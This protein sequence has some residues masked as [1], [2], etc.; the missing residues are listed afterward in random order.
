MEGPWNGAKGDNKYQYNGKE[1]NDD[2]GLGWNDYGARFYDAAVGRWM[3]IDPMSEKMPHYSLYNYAFNNPIR[4][5]DPD[6]M[7]PTPPGRVIA[8]FFH[9]GPKG[10]GKT[11]TDHSYSKVGATGT[12]FNDTYKAVDA[13]GMTMHG[14]IIA[15]G[16]TSSSGVENGLNFLKNADI[17]VDD[18]VLIYGYS[19]GGDFAVELAQAAKEAGIPVDL[20]ITVDASDGPLGQTTVDNII[21]DNVRENQNYYQTDHLGNFFIV[22]GANRATGSKS[23]S[24]SGKSN[25][26]GSHGGKNYA[27]NHKLTNVQNHN[28]TGKK[29]NGVKVDHGN[30][31]EAARQE[32]GFDVMV[33]LHRDAVHD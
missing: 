8:V 24:D 11:Q 6:G 12:I 9:G 30:I 5:V 27:K 23:E 7:E 31:Q 19:Y 10:E 1:W 13:A 20:L 22:E 32:I 4:F 21:P 2:F 28:K 3:T 16:L 29:V 17:G 18:K 26:M 14:I 33:L 25:W 15:P